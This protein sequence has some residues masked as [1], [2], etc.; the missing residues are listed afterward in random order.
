[1]INNYQAL[2]HRYKEIIKENQLIKNELLDLRNKRKVAKVTPD[3][4]FSMPLNRL[5]ASG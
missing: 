5:D 4:S 3:S 1:M 2:E